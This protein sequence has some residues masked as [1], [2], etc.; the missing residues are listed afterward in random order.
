[1]NKLFFLIPASGAAAFLG[2]QAIQNFDISVSVK[3][4]E[5]TQSFQTSQP[6]LADASAFTELEPP[7]PATPPHLYFEEGDRV[8]RHFEYPVLPATE[9][10]KIH[11]IP[12]HADIAEHVQEMIDAAAKDGVNLIPLSGFRS[13]EKQDFLWNRAIKRKGSEFN[14]AKTSAPPFHSE[15]HTGYAI[16]FYDANHPDKMLTE[17]FEDTPAFEWLQANAQD[18]SFELSFP[19]DNAQQLSYEP[20]HWRYVGDEKSAA[21][22]NPVKDFLDSL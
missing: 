2:V 17:N 22:F 6:I 15:H 13:A 3:A 18:W 21:L 8:I 19:K 16:D 14:A 5:P 1:M 9:L 10:G 20:W 4:D 11:D 12:V 7:A